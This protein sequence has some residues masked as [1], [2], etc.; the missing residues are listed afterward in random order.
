M[1]SI[2]YT[3]VKT[4]YSAVSWLLS[5]RKVSTIVKPITKTIK[6][7]TIKTN[8]VLY[9]FERSDPGMNGKKFYKVGKSINVHQRCKSYYTLDPC[10]KLV[11]TVKCDDIH[12]TEKLLHMI[13]A[14]HGYKVQK[15]V[16]LI[17]KEKLIHYMNSAKILGD[18]LCIKGND[19]K[20]LESKF[21]SWFSRV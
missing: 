9:A 17:E 18:Y 13:L 14:K 11:H 21:K 19:A 16:F 6:K 15:E 20:L 4:S 8:H 12:F 1:Y 5:L 7:P 3:G 10:G 2:L